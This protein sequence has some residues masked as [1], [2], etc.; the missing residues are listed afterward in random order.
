MTKKTNKGAAELLT[1]GYA[2]EV[3]DIHQ[4]MIAIMLNVGYVQK[5]SSPGLNYTFAGEVALIKALRPVMLDHRVYAFPLSSSIVQSDAYQTGRGTS[6]QRTKVQLVTRFVHAPSGTHI[7]VGTCGEGADSSDKSTAK[8]TTSAYKYALREAFLIETGDDGDRDRPEGP[9][10]APATK[11][12]RDPYPQDGDGFYSAPPQKAGGL[13]GAGGTQQACP[14][15]GK[16]GVQMKY[17]KPGERSPDLEC[18]GDCTETYKDG[19]P[20]PLRWWSVTR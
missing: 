2:D 8:A 7:D 11:R 19:P 4:A 6:M 10:A 14:K 15:C 13:P 3:A 12:Q 9:A 5:E 20:R 17:W 18:S 16:D 1:E